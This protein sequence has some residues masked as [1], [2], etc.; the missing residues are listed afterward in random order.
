MISCNSGTRVGNNTVVLSIASSGGN[1]EIIWS[2][3]A[4]GG[5]VII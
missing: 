2:T 5:N 1:N 4:S 3:G